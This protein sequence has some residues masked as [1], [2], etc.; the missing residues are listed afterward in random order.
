MNQLLSTKDL[1]TLAIE[2]NQ[3]DKLAQEHKES[4]ISYAVKC[5]G[6][7]SSAKSLVEHGQWLN[8]H[9]TTNR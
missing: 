2:I 3:A 4:A 1:P 7:L 8:W 6:A 9:T 5:G